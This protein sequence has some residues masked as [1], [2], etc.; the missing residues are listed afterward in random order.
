MVEE[1]FYGERTGVE[2][3][4]EFDC[5]EEPEIKPCEPEEIR[6]S[7]RS[8][9]L[10]T[11]LGMI[12]GD[13]VELT[14]D[15]QRSRVWR[16]REKSRLIES[17]LLQIPLPAFYFAEDEDGMFRVVDGLQRLSAVHE[18]V[19]GAFALGDLEYLDEQGK[20][21]DQL[22]APL[23]RRL[24]NTDIVVHVIEP[25]TPSGAEYGIFKRINTYEEPLNAREIRHRMSGD[26]SR[27][28]LE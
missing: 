10:R 4:R 24:L 19:S 22:T 21:F 7:T 15:F 28:M 8:F 26:R 23:R 25:S 12:R 17:L 14:P 5:A 2:V 9:A 20:T 11:V 18:F 3:E 16:H 1:V 13:R 6:V 27:V